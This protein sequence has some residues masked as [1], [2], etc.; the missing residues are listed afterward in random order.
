[1]DALYFEGRD[2]KPYGEFASGPSLVEGETY[3][4]VH[5]VDDQMFVP[6]LRPLVFIGRDREQGDSGQL[7][8]QDAG[9]YLAGARYESATGTDDAEFHTVHQDTPFVFE[10]ELALDVLLRCSLKRRERRGSGHAPGA[11]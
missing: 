1:M 6:E 11:V 2:L 5:F 8:F 9:S 4:A 3:F 7:Y 10:F